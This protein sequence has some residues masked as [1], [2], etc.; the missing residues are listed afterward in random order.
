MKII[1]E[2][3][4][5]I[6]KIISEIHQKVDHKLRKIATSPEFGFEDNEYKDYFR[7]NVN[8]VGDH[9]IKVEVG[10]EVSYDGLIEICDGLNTVVEKYDKDS[11]FEPVDPGI[12]E[13]WIELSNLK[14]RRNS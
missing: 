1:K 5:K 2:S 12:I 11:Y 3:N 4:I 13:C 14:R 7:V 9:Q 6:D 10:A 8:L